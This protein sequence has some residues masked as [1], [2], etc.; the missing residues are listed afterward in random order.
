MDENVNSLEYIRSSDTLQLVGPL[1]QL[2]EQ[3]ALNLCVIGSNPIRPTKIQVVSSE[4]TLDLALLLQ[5]YKKFVLIQI[6]R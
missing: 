3:E 4:I 5:E 2:V 1:A 6:V